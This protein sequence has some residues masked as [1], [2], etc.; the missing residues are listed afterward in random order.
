MGK[1]FLRHAALLCLGTVTLFPF[2]WMVLTSFKPPSEIFLDH[3]SW[4]PNQFYGF[5][6]Y[7][8]AF[9]KA[10]LG[11]YLI[12]GVIVTFSI[13]ILQ[14]MIA[15]PAAYALAKLRFRGR[16]FLFASVLVCLLI[17][18]H[19]V[20]IPV[21]LL[22]HK[23]GLLN[24]YASL[25]LPWTISV[26]GIFLMRQFFLTIPDD[27]LDAGR[28]D[29]MSEFGMI[30]RIVIPISYPVLTAFGIFSL[31]AHW[32]D[33]FWPLIAVNDQSLFTPPLGVAHFR[34]DDAGTNYGALMAAATV[35][36]TPLIIIFMFLQRRFVQGIALSG[37]K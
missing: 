28:M 2:I 17:P 6:N 12:N 9:T 31:V 27:L 3:I 22:L 32:N 15:L 11:R 10:P 29:G 20:A 21:F 1:S 5:E 35:V 13:F 36:I 19:A 14:V 33:Y 30:W 16:E 37:M 25:I 8:T 23:I 18:P 4:W 24:T 34:N 26:F 7:K